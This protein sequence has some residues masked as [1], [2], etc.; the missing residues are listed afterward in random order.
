MW[1]R[2]GEKPLKDKPVYLLDATPIIYYTK[3]G[4][5]GLL[6][7]ICE[8]VIVEAVYNEVTVGDYPDAYVVRDLVEEGVLRVYRVDDRGPVEGLMRFPE[9]HL[10]E[11]ETLVA[12]RLLGGVAV[13]D[14]SA[15]WAVAEVFG[16]KVARGTLFLLFRLLAAGVIDALD[17]EDM[18]ELLVES[19]LYLDPRTVLKAKSLLEQYKD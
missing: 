1:R 14:D 10:G 9:I 18:L 3:I 13:V 2:L 6:S 7:L 11:A 19:G 12:S 5:L 17:A 16:F 15:A 8:P 4:K